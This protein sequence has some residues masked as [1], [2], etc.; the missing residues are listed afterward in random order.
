MEFCLPL[1]RRGCG[2]EINIMLLAM[3][4]CLQNQLEVRLHSKSWTARYQKDWQDDFLSF[5]SEVDGPL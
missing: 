5:R 1:Y 2:S 4:Y 3:L